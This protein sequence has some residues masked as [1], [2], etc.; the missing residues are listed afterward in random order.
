MLLNALIEAVIT[1]AVVTFFAAILIGTN[2][3]F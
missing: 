3:P 2:V 1:A